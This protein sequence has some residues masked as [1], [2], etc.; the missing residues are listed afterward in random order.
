M[1]RDRVESARRITED[2]KVVLEKIKHVHEFFKSFEVVSSAIEDVSVRHLRMFQC[3]TII[4]ASP[5]Y[6]DCV[7]RD[8]FGIQGKP[9][10]L[11]VDG[12]LIA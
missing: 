1:M 4:A 12:D 3:L 8:P 7:H 5:R 11:E 2:Q 6:Q 10:L 9:L